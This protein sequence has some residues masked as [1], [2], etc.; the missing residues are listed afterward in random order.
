MA[1]IGQRSGTLSS[2]AQRATIHS[3]TAHVGA[4][5]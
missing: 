5:A 2:R 1:S 4:Y 3:P